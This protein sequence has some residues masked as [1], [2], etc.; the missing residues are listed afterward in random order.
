V[1][2]LDAWAVAATFLMADIGK[3][4][5]IQIVGLGYDPKKAKPAN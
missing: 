1:T 4:P 5:L 3:S 2:R